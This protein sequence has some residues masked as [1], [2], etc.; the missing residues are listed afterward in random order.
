L[1]QIVVADNGIDKVPRIVDYNIVLPTFTGAGFASLYHNSGAFGLA[2]G[3]TAQIVGWIGREDPT[4][5]AEALGAAMRVPAPHAAN[6]VRLLVE[7]WNKL[8]LPAPAWVMPMSHWAHELDF[9][10]AAW[11]PAALRSI[12]I[13]PSALQPRADGSAIEF[14]GEES[15]QLHDFCLSLLEN[16][17]GSDFAIAFPDKPALCTLHHHGQLWW[18]TADASLRDSLRALAAE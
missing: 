1:C 7:A 15:A 5:R 6:L 2:P 12:G 10:S 14:A 4:L 18:T 9:A 16:L 3:T 8:L 11:M 17:R 13:D